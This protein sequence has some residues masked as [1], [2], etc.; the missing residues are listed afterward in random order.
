MRQSSHRVWQTWRQMKQYEPVRGIS[1]NWG[2]VTEANAYS[3]LL[4]SGAMRYIVP[5]RNCSI[6]VLVWRSMSSEDTLRPA[7]GLDVDEAERVDA[8]EEPPVD[9]S[10][11]EE[12]DAEDE[13]EEVVDE[14]D[15]EGSE[16]V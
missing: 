9:N 8:V 2:T 1:A 5:S 11:V 15:V 7:E 6:A 16:R 3:D 10:K 13:E 4:R 14:V 12:E